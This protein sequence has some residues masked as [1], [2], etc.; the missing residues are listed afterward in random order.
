MYK[1]F[2]LCLLPASCHSLLK[3]SLTTG[4][5]YESPSDPQQLAQSDLDNLSPESVVLEFTFSLEKYD[6]YK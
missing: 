4:K 6:R 1:F 5:N 3:S 2:S